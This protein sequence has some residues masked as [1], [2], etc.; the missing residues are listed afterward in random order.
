MYSLHVR[1]DSFDGFVFT[2]L[3]ASSCKQINSSSQVRLSY[4]SICKFGAGFDMN[5]ASQLFGAFQRFH[6]EDEFPGTG[7]GLATVRRIVN[8]HGGVV[9]AES[10]PGA[11]AVFYFTLGIPGTAA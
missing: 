2:F 4:V 3:Y 5:N 7:V 9:Y 6:S 11:G 8:R 10:A 1:Y